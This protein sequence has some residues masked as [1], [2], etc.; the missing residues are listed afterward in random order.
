[1]RD[2]ASLPHRYTQSPLANVHL[3]L[4]N[5]AGIEQTRFADSTAMISEI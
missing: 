1:M 5:K 2:I 3:T 4:L